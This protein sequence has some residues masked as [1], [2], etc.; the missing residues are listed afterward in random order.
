M[1]KSTIHANAVL[2][3]I[4]DLTIHAGTYISLHTGDPGTTGASEASGAGASNYA[5]VQVNANGGAAPSWGAAAAAA[6]A[7]VGAITFP[8][9]GDDQVITHF[10]V[11]DAASAG[12]FIRGGALDS[13]FTYAAN[14]TPEF[15]AGALE[16]TE[17]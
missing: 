3:N 10:G 4:G 14:V 1:A 17:A 7:N 12:N 9:G 6:M 8:Q 15:A 16:L 5:R 11:Y 2:D 13:Q